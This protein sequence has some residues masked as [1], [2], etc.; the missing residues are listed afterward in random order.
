MTPE[1]HLQILIWSVELVAV[2]L[3]LLIYFVPAI[4]AFRRKKRNRWAIFW[5]DL[6]TAWSVLGWLA[7]FIWSLSEYG[8]RDPYGLVGNIHARGYS[9]FYGLLATCQLSA[10]GL[11]RFR[12]W[13][14][15]APHPER[16]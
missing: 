4:V 3:V 15:S 11:F 1:Q 6:L 16:N 7:S 9:G 14:Q 13:T 2:A 5:L 12:R 10:A 8:A